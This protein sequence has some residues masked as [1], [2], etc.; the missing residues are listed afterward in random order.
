MIHIN[1]KQNILNKTNLRQKSKILDNLNYFQT[2]HIVLTFQK[3]RYG[4]VYNFGC[5]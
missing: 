3:K 5:D 1:I 4:L 2:V